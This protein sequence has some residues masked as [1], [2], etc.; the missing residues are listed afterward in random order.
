MALVVRNPTANAGDLRD[1]G[2]IPRWKIPWRR[3]H[4]NPLQ[5]SCLEN[6][7]DR[8]AW[9][10]TVHGV[11]QSQT[12]LSNWGLYVYEPQLNPEGPQSQFSQKD[13]QVSLSLASQKALQ[14]HRHLLDT[15]SDKDSWENPQGRKPHC[16]RSWLWGSRRAIVNHCSGTK[17]S[18]RKLCWF[19]VSLSARGGGGPGGDTEAPVSP[20]VPASD[21][22]GAAAKIQASV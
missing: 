5:Y 2:S 10:A 14:A 9:W 1:M 13:P 16:E 22:W 19:R 11:T 20:G 7:M 4:G 3:G 21:S 6:P 18:S 12:Q 15:T 17:G 8:G